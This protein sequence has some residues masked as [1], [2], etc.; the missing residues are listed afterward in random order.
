MVGVSLSRWTMSYFSAALFALVGAEMLMVAGY[1]FPNQPVTAPQTLVLVHL[2][3]V[4]WLSLLMSGALIQFVPVL[5]AKPL[6][7]PELPAAALALLVGGLASLILGFLG[8]TGLATGSMPWLP[9]GA[10]SLLA[11]FLLNLWNL[12]R[13]LWSAR[14]I[15]LPARFVA[16][17]LVSL[18]GVVT[19]GTIFSVTLGGWTSNAALIRLTSEAIPL[20][21]ALGLGGWL[22][23]TAMGVS[24]RLL[25]MFMLA[26]ESEHRTSRI[27]LVTGTL[28]IL[29]LLIGGPVCILVFGVAV[30]H[31][32]LAA[33]ALAIVS[34]ALYGHDIVRLYRARKRQKIELNARM[35]AV[36]L[37]GLGL[38]TLL[39]L[40]VTLRGA[41]DGRIGAVA[42]LFAFGW[43][44]GLGLAKLYKIV[45]FLTWLECYGELLGK[46]ATPRVQDLVN[47]PRAT[48]WFWLYFAS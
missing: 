46:R 7:H 3:A 15:N 22:S 26:P 10:I 20:H 24:Y 16:V 1:G 41:V 48:P 47:E 45:A 32:L 9:L 29:I 18:V 44:T 5:V 4:G 14:P 43:P 33:L 17:G 27:A 39:L 28:A 36:A 40:A 35:A 38:A 8:M 37:G 31:P 21:A 42:F 30:T 2:V 19:F 6:V 25:A 11:G 12:G 34:L 13:T 23:F